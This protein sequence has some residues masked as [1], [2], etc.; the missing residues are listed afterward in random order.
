MTTIYVTHPRYVEHDLAGHPEHAGRI[1]AVW[2]RLDEAGLTTRMRSVEATAA[3]VDLLRTVHTPGYLA[4]LERIAGH[5]RLARLDADT[6][7]TPTSYEIALLSAGGIV[8]AVRAVMSGEANNGLAAV[9][10][11]GHHAMP[12][13]AMGFC[14]LGNVAIAARY[15]QQAHGIERVLIVDYDVHH[16]NGTEAMFYDDPTV[17]FIST[18][19]WPLYPGTGAL[20]D[21]GTG[22][23]QG[24]NI[25]I[26]MPPGNGD[27][28]YAAVFEQV[29]WP[30]AQR[31]HPQ[32]IIASVGHDAHWT[33]P[34]ASMRLSLK[35]YAHLAQELALMARELCGGKI[36][37]LME[38][39]YDLDALSYGMANI[40]RVLLGDHEIIDPLG[41]AQDGRAEPDIAPLIER[42]Q[43]IHGLTASNVTADEA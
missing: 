6:Y 27:A 34:L 33:D 37:F 7:V 12:D 36:V 18:H 14:I 19:Q 9:R 16:G 17:L 41:P 28:N 15:A 1:R 2:K 25:N 43:K 20:T 29:I 39:G 35:G 8:D 10:P 38:G 40:A 26:P 4:L 31:F 24:C 30:A 11:P 42:V 32:L 23:G 13:R 22:K 3:P 5:E 21:T